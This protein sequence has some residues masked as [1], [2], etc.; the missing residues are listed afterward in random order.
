M[1]CNVQVCRI[2][3]IQQKLGVPIVFYAW[4]DSLDACKLQAELCDFDKIHKYK[5]L[6]L[7]FLSC[8]FKIADFF[9]GSDDHALTSNLNLSRKKY[10]EV[11]F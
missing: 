9:M 11:F 8:R 7:S 6:T 2:L 10:P 1:A 5:K 3:K 4:Y